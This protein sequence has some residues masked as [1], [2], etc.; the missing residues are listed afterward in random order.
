MRLARHISWILLFF[1]ILMDAC[2]PLTGYSEGFLEAGKAFTV[3]AVLEQDGNITL[4][5]TIAKGYKLYRDRIRASV[6]DG[7]ATISEPLLPRGITYKDPTTGEKLEI[8][9]GRVAATLPVKKAE[10]PF[11]LK[12]EY[13]G[14]AD[15]GL[16]YP[17]A[18]KV[19]SVTPGRTGELP[20]ASLPANLESGKSTGL[21]VG[22]PSGT[23]AADTAVT[24]DELSLARST[25][26]GG[27]LW[28]IAMVFLI[29][30]LLLSFTPCVLPMLPIL[31]SIIVG[32]GEAGRGRTFLLAVSYSIG[33]AMVYTMMGVAAGL[34]GEGFAGALQKP[35]VLLLF[36]LMLVAFSLSMFDVYQLQLPVSLQNRLV[37]RSGK[38]GGGRFLGVF[39]MGAVSA[40]IVGPCVAAPLAGTL[41]YISQTRNVVVGGLAL[42]SMATGMS[43]PLL[44]LGMSAG[45]ILPKAGPWMNGVKHLFGI[46]LI[47]VAIWMVTPVLES[48][49]ILV[50][51]GLLAILA[52]VYTGMFRSGSG[53]RRLQVI[54]IRAIGVF[55]LLVGAVEIFGAISGADDPLAPLSVFRRGGEER[56]SFRR[57]GTIEELDRELRNTDRPVMLDFYADWCVTCKELEQNTFSDPRVMAKLSGMRL[58]QVDVTGN[59]AQD[60]A[61]MKRYGIFGPPAIVFFDRSGKEA[62]GS[63][64]VGFVDA[65]EFLKQLERVL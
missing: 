47:G 16:C 1:L 11:R 22:S 24:Y 60:R 44:L 42:F 7:K 13:Q 46:L 27:S 9:H 64:I 3:K 57:I 4:D 30:G 43:V 38:L 54:S 49:A 39:L 2:L 12:I 61:L 55:M 31:S 53:K 41:V 62:E 50:A 45:R 52:A 65:A 20:L 29:F 32:E 19:F 15:E 56:I 58:L 18:E 17:P 51:W 10:G 26:A 21:T 35:W 33:M 25:L 48:R 59:T 6:V 40:L 37:K 28:K 23:P 34:A 5:L 36:S 14:C 63:R 8:Y